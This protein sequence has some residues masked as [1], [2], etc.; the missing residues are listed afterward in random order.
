MSL[1]TE[2]P[3]DDHRNYNREGKAFDVGETFSGVDFE[4]GLKA[5]E[6]LKR[7]K[8]ENISLVQLALKWI[9]MYNEVSCVIPGAKSAKQVEENTSVSELADLSPE[10]MRGIKAVYEKFIKPSVHQRW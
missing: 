2:F 4:T 6:E 1:K 7:L 10:T 9:L 8:P 3:A 5:V